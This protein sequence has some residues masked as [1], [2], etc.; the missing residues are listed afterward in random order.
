[1]TAL[2]ASTRTLL[3]LAAIATLCALPAQAQHPQSTQ[4]TLTGTVTDGH[5]PLHG[6]VVELQNPANNSVETY[7]TDA[8]GHY[9]FKRLAGDADYRIWVVFRGHHTPTR[10]ISKFDNHMQKTI[11]FTVKPY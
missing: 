7:L 3:T 1:M 2:S 6:A 9:T 4:R 11:D 5:E 8:A 10:S